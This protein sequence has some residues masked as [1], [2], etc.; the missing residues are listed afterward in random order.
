MDRLATVLPLLPA[1][2]VVS[3]CSAKVTLGDAASDT[4]DPL[5]IQD[6]ITRRL[7]GLPTRASAGGMT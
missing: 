1:A 4:I 3:G 7:Q 6:A 5:R 2:A